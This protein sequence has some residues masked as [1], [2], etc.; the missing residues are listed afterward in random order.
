MFLAHLKWC[1]IPLSARPSVQLVVKFSTL[2][3]GYERVH[4]RTQLSKIFS[5]FVCCRLTMTSFMMSFTY[6]SKVKH[7]SLNSILL[8]ISLFTALFSFGSHVLGLCIQK[9]LYARFDND[10][11]FTHKMEMKVA[12]TGTTDNDSMSNIH[13]NNLF[14]HSGTSMYWEFTSIANIN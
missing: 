13:N 8:F 4:W 14:H 7:I 10:T 3:S 1:R 9:R 11:K 5:L 12:I 2:T 6:R